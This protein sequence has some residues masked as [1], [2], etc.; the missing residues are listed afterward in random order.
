MTINQIQ[1]MFTKGSVW[2]TDNSY[3]PRVNGRREIVAVF[4]TQFQWRSENG[5]S[6]FTP[7]PVKSQVLEVREGFIRFQIHK[8][9]DCDPRQNHWSVND[10]L[11][12]TRVSEVQ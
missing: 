1:A 6:G 8:A 9:K 10:T 2:I 7:W 4:A 11:T 12:L 3:N 5:L